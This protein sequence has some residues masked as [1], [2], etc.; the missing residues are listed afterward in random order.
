MPKKKKITKKKN[1][2]PFVDEITGERR[3]LFLAAY[4][5][6]GS[7]TYDNAY[8]SAIKA[9]F[10]H[11]Y[12]KNIITRKPQ[13]LSEIVGNSTVLKDSFEALQQ[14]IRMPVKSLVMTAFG[15]YRD[16]KTKKTMEQLDHNLIQKRQNAYM[17]ALEKLHPDYKKKDK[18]EIQAHSV[19][20]KQ[21]F[22]IEP[23]GEKIPYNTLPVENK[24]ND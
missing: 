12:S 7:P 14:D 5:D 13:W 2:T 18:F 6:P 24:S 17:F 19:E 20:F 9:G 22:I 1:K 23:T 4:I 3:K 8:Q 16:K 21:I 15:P 11:E 10:T